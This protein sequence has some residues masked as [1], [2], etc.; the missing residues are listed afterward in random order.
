MECTQCASLKSFYLYEYE[1]RTAEILI[2]GLFSRCSIIQR[3]R[4]MQRENEKK[5]EREREIEE[6]L[7]HIEAKLMHFNLF[8]GH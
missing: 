8:T 2:Y 1:R 7:I 3:Y 6:R 5:R 4:L